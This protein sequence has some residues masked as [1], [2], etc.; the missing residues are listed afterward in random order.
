MEL[1][2]SSLVRTFSLSLMEKRILLLSMLAFAA[3]C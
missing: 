3:M 2:Q 1:V